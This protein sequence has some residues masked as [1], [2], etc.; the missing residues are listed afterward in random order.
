M[1]LRATP[2]AAHE[3]RFPLLRLSR[4]ATALLAAHV[5]F[6]ASV[7]SAERIEQAAALRFEPG[8]PVPFLGLFTSIPGNYGLRDAARFVE[9]ISTANPHITGF[10]VRLQW[11]VFHPEPDR[12]D[13]AGLEEL[14]TAAAKADKLITL[15]LIPGGASPHWIYQA[16]AL[17]VGPVRM[18]ARMIQTPLPWDPG[19]M[20][21]YTADLEAIAARYGNDPRLFGVTVLGHN[22]NYAGEE[23]HAPAVDALL[24]F[25]WTEQ[26]VVENW[27]HWIDTYA[28]LF[29]AKRLALVVSQ[30]YRRAPERITRAIVAHFA[31]RAVGRG[32]LQTHQLTG[33]GEQL[34]FGPSICLEFRDRLPASHEVYS[35]MKLIPGRTGP[36]PM[37]IYNAIRVAPVPFLQIWSRD[38]GDPDISRTLLG[39]W[40]KYGSLTPA[41]AKALLQQESD[42]VPHPPPTRAAG[43]SPYD[44]PRLPPPGYPGHNDPALLTWSPL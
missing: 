34:A 20:E 15:S 8:Q 40:E 5:S 39:V 21:L 30:T 41:E 33:R 27:R 13:W 31:D 23:M 26:T 7:S 38:A 37:Y 9:E 3:R 1:N 19:F 42:Y 35:S 11:R 29:P 25:G 17:R 24:P 43:F 12:I 2:R 18:G 22:F 28:R 16:G 14:L 6:L 36:L 4:F 44:L 32:Y 10:T